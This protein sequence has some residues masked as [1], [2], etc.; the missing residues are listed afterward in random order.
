MEASK[1]TLPIFPADGKTPSQSFPLWISAV[2]DAA[3]RTPLAY[4]LPRGII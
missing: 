2:H 3:S 4:H 1:L